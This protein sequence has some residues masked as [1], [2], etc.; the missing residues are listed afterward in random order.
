MLYNGE[1]SQNGFLKA[2]DTVN[3]VKTQKSS[4][5][6]LVSKKLQGGLLDKLGMYE[7]SGLNALIFVD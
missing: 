6:I 1:S 2:K 4:L 7:C 3:S 5:F